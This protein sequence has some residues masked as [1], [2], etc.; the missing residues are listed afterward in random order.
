MFKKAL[1]RHIPVCLNLWV[2]SSMDNHMWMRMPV[3]GKIP[4]GIVYYGKLQEKFIAVY[5]YCTYDCPTLSISTLVTL[6]YIHG[7]WRPNSKGMC[8]LCRRTWVWFPPWHIPQ[9]CSLGVIVVYG[10]WCC[11]SWIVKL[12]VGQAVPSILYT[13]YIRKNGR[14]CDQP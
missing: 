9:F 2:P 10:S 1:E 7:I 3:V 5:L 6:W 12:W 14:K 13:L 4:L 8:K 11:L